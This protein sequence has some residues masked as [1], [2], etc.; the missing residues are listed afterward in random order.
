MAT[1]QINGDR[2]TVILS[3]PDED[4]DYDWM[5]QTCGQAADAIRPLDEAINYA[6]NHTD[7]TCEGT[8]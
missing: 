4:G 8:A 3:P 5:C 7:L 6:E 2:A 1:I